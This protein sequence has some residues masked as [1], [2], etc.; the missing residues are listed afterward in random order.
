MAKYSVGLQGVAPWQQLEGQVLQGRVVHSC[1]ARP[2]NHLQVLLYCCCVAAAAVLLRWCFYCCL[3]RCG[4]PCVRN[5]GLMVHP[6]L[7]ARGTWYNS[8]MLYPSSL[9][10]CRCRKSLEALRPICACKK[11]F[12]SSQLCDSSVFRSY[13]CNT[14][15]PGGAMRDCSFRSI[16]KGSYH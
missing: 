2:C 4:L 1:V 9:P 16:Q 3:L 5:W 15:M 7:S 14:H 10:P 8:A 6:W 13:H 12:L 11:E